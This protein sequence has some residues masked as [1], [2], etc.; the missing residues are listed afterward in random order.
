[1][2]HLGL[3]TESGGEARPGQW[4]GRYNGS[5]EASHLSPVA[6]IAC[7][8]PAHGFGPGQVRSR[9]PREADRTVVKEEERLA[10]LG[11]GGF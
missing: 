7:S 4:M 3:S 9:L 5:G 11:I 1:M 6:H 10:M 2:I 8:F